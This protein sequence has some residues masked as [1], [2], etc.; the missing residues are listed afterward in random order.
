M[1]LRIL[2]FLFEEK[3]QSQLFKQCCLFLK[4]PFPM[5]SFPLLTNCGILQCKDVGTS[6][7]Q[8]WCSLNNICIFL[9][10]VSRS[11]FGFCTT[12]WFR[13]VIPPSSKAKLWP[14]LRSFR[15]DEVKEDD[16]NEWKSWTKCHCFWTA[17]L[18]KSFTLVCNT[19]LANIITKWLFFLL[20]LLLNWFLAVFQLQGWPNLKCMHPTFPLW[21]AMHW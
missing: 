8:K 3:I 18:Q 2:F 10:R 4:L 5:I 12:S 9:V 13:L 19:E 1:H 20:L 15:A 21:I 6:W 7:K 11:Q 14:T 17:T 16:K